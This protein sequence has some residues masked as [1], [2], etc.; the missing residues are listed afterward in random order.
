[1]LL[2]LDIGNSRIKWGLFSGLVGQAVGHFSTR[3][4][5]SADPLAYEFEPAAPPDAP[6]SAGPIVPAPLPWPSPLQ[7]EWLHGVRQLAVCSV[8]A[9]R[10]ENTLLDYLHDLGLPRLPVWRVASA[11]QALGVINGYAEPQRLGVDRWAALVAAR[12]LGPLPTVVVM[13]GTA[14]T[15]D[16]LEADGRFLGGYIL[17]GLRLMP[18]SLFERTAG[19]RPDEGRWS[20]FPRATADGVAS[21][22]LAATAGAVAG[23]ALSLQRRHPGGAVAVLVS[24]GNGPTLIARIAQWGLEP[25]YQRD[26]VLQGI[27]RLFGEAADDHAQA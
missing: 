6:D 25:I 27:A 26:L 7:P 1:M 19:I 17:P 16:A 3:D 24:G 14:T 21:G 22:V 12:A 11:R 15:V 13:A 5:L 20:E 9:P 23:M 8:A 18:K 10:T 2:A 4:F